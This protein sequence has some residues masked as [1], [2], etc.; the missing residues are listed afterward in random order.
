MNALQLAY[1]ELSF[2]RWKDGSYYFFHSSS[3]WH[4][5]INEHLLR[6]SVIENK[7]ESRWADER[8]CRTF[9]DDFAKE[10]GFDPLVPENWYSLNMARLLEK[11]VSCQKG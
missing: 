3:L 7:K 2:E 5:L 4:N 6:Q 1:P 10:K 9:F 8:F 11:K